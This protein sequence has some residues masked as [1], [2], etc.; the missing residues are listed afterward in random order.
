MLSGLFGSCA[1]NAAFHDRMIELAGSAA[2]VDSFRRLTVP[3]IM[4]RS[5]LTDEYADPGMAS[6]HIALME[7]YE[8]G[9]I[10]AARC[11]LT[12]DTDRAIALHRERLA[13]VGGAI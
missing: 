5:L 1:A 3:G 13:A 11:A 7:A 4:S 8:R 9:D 6:D 12:S 2:L 10:D